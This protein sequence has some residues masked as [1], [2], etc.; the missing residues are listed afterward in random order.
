MQAYATVA[1]NVFALSSAF[2]VLRRAADLSSMIKSAEDFSNRFGRSV[3]RITRQ[4][5]EASGGA[6]TFAEALPT[7]N[8]AISA[9]IGTEQLEKLTKAAT[10]AAQTFGGTANEALNR[11]IRIMEL[12]LVK[13]LRNLLRSTDNKLSLMQLLRKVKMYLPE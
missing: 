1:A 3:T 2:L 6:L 9:G 13:Q 12:L 5:Q 4:M 8:K 10:L 7:I 11:F